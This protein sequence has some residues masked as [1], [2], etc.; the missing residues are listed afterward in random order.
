MSGS[1]GI[2]PAPPQ[3]DDAGTTNGRLEESRQR[4]EP[5][6]GVAEE[7]IGYNTN[8]SEISGDS[9]PALPEDGDDGVEKQRNGD[10]EKLEDSAPEEASSDEYGGDDVA[11]LVEEEASDDGDRDGGAQEK[12]IRGSDGEEEVRWTEWTVQGGD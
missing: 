12:E 7:S 11:A 1:E 5:K 6:E 2:N 8:G 4:Q 9:P 10:E 3:G